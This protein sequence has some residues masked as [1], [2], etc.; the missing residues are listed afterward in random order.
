VQGH[1]SAIDSRIQPAT[2]DLFVPWRL[3]SLLL[4]AAAS[5]SLAG[6]SSGGSP[7]GAIGGE[8]PK[9]NAA[10]ATFLRSMAAHE[11]ATL[12]I[13]RLAARRALRLELRRIARTMT[14]EQ[15]SETS[16][17]D[18]LAQSLAGRGARP[19][20]AMS[21]P[22]PALADLARVTDAT[23]FDYEFMRTMIERNQSAVAIALH[24]V[25]FGSDPEVKRL[26]AAI[27]RSR[28]K[29]LERLAGWLHLWYGGPIQP[30]PP[31][32]APPGG[33]GG[34]KPNPGPG[35]GPKGPPV[36]L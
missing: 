29:E 6:C 16:E 3:R 26:A 8:R 4:A 12:G 36:Q 15:E 11:E 10:D 21:A 24:E 5:A 31:S 25:R 1:R 14:S 35:G 22:N 9:P 30:D 34:Q 27:A 13:T 23:S 7:F 20:A 2:Y 32:I 18:S 17:L 19:P 28:Q 33:G